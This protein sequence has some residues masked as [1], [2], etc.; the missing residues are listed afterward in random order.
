[1]QEAVDRGPHWSA[2]SDEA[3]AHFQAEVAK[4]VKMGQATLVAWD[5]IKDSLPVELKISPIAAIPQKSK[6]FDPSWTCHFTCA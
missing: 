1:M 6:Q 4:K 5:S 2:L 3:I